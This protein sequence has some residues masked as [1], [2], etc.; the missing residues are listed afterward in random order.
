MTAEEIAR[1]SCEQ[2]FGAIDRKAGQVA[3][4]DAGVAAGITMAASGEG[5]T[6]T[7]FADSSWRSLGVVAGYDAY[8]TETAEQREETA[9]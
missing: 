4:F 1:A 7:L 3:E 8:F 2:V 9:A 5:L 6:L